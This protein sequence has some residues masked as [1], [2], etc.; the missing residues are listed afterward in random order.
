M[1][2][3]RRP[4]RGAA[5]HACA[6]LASVPLALAIGAQRAGA[7]DAPPTI[8][9]TWSTVAAR[10]GDS[11]GYVLFQ[12]DCSVCHGTG[13]A[14][15]GT[16]ALAAKYKGA[17]PALIDARTDLAPDYIRNIVRHGVSVMPPFRKT[18]LSD[19]DLDALVA[20]LTRRR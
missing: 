2:S 4:S 10:P 11:R 3:P 16:R 15:P 8:E 6:L 19:T 18:E 5:G 17:R 20:Y 1:S 13:A 14:K 12:A 7:T 9:W